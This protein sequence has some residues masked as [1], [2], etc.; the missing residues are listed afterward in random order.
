MKKICVVT[1]ARSEYGLLKWLMH[2]IDADPDF[3]LQLIVTGGHLLKEQGHTIDAIISDG[4]K[5]KAIVDANLDITSTE[6]IASSMGRMAEKFAPVFSQLKPDILFVLGDRYEL[7]PICNTA[8]VMRIPIAHLSGGDVT[9]GAIDDGVRNS[10][11]MLA[12]YHF[13][14]PPDSAKNVERM[15]GS[16][17]N[18]W[19]VGEPGLDAFNRMELMSRAELAENLELDVNKKWC[20]MTYHS[21]T[22]ESLEYNLSA[23]QSCFVSL[24]KYNDLQIVMTYANADFGG[25]KINKKLEKQAKD[26]PTQF[27]VIP[28]LGQLRYLS[29][30][31]QVSL[32]IGNSSSGI[33]EAPFLGIPVVNIGER[34]KGRYQCKNIIQCENNSC[35]IQNAVKTALKKVSDKSDCG[36]WGDGHAAEKILQIIRE[37]IFNN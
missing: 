1:A 12:D 18:I 23:V 33:V 9:E 32:V 34:Q 15:R 13:P 16:N 37:R 27:K 8:F 2:D 6:T 30:M 7:L 19:A 11:S 10:V 25:D 20:L 4:F 26:N 29:Y 36:Y 31:K 5:I 3:Q 21:E 14:G 24:S 17:K 35:A 28:S 22:H